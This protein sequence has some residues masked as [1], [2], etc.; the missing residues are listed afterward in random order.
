MQKSEKIY[1]KKM[2]GWFD[3]E[4]ENAGKMREMA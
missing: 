4:G 3:L 1:S 2:E